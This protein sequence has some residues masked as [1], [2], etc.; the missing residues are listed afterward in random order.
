MLQNICCNCVLYC[1]TILDI[2]C[3]TL[4]IYK[5]TLLYM[6]DHVFAGHKHFGVIDVLGVMITQ[7]KLGTRN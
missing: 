1:S 2:H 4:Q 6:Y 5:F 7:F 3:Q